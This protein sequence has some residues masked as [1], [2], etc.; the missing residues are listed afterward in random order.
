MP[1]DATLLAYN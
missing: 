1:G